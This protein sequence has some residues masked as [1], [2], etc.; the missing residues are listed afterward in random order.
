MFPNLLTLELPTAQHGSHG[1]IS[2]LKK[3][4]FI[5]V[6]GSP[7]AS[8]AGLASGDPRTIKSKTQMLPAVTRSI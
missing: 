8:I 7:L 1:S 2:V 4:F 3:A 5:I 6:R